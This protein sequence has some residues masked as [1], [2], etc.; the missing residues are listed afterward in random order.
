MAYIYR[1]WSRGLVRRLKVLILP[2][3]F[4]KPSFALLY[5]IN[6][7]QLINFTINSYNKNCI[8]F[9]NRRNPIDLINI[10]II[11]KGTLNNVK[12]QLFRDLWLIKLYLGNLIL[13]YC[14]KNQVHIYLI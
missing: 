8:G 4:I 7:K 6:K 5:L 13:T 12:K 11:G 1:C 10:I 14:V 2:R 3:Q 9:Q